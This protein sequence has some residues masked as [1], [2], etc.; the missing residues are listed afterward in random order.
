MYVSCS[1]RGIAVFQ[2]KDG[3][4][5]Y[6]SLLVLGRELVLRR[7]LSDGCWEGGEGLGKEE[8]TFALAIRREPHGQILRLAYS[9]AAYSPSKSCPHK[10]HTQSLD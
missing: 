10:E 3:E 7:I 6:A 1:E 9:L 5:L 4:R 2:L 8:L